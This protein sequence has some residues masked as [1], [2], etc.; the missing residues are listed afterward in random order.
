M[1]ELFTVGILSRINDFRLGESLIKFI[2][3]GLLLSLSLSFSLS[4]TQ[5]PVYVIT[6]ITIWFVSTLCIL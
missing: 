6:L 5:T 3:D 2:D 4:H 1:S